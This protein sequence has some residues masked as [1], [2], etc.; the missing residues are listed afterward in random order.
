MESISTISA[1][2]AVSEMKDGNIR[3]ASFKRGAN[4]CGS[5]VVRRRG[6]EAASGTDDCFLL[7]PLRFEGMVEIGERH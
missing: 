6:V 3:E 1:T 4:C 5:A 7:L 2:K